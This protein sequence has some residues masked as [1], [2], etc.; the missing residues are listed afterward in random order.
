MKI[1][2]IGGTGVYG[3]DILENAKDIQVDTAFGAAKVRV[4]E[5]RGEEIAFLARHGYSHSVL[6]H[7]INYKANIA[8]LK[9]LGVTKVISTCAVGTLNADIHPGSFALLDQF[10]DFTKLRSYTYFHDTVAHVDFTNPYCKSLR[11]I[12]LK[13]A[14]E[15]NIVVSP[16]GCYGCTEGPRYETTAEISMM[17]KLGVDVVGMTNV[18]EVILAREAELCYSCIAIATNWAA[19]ITE[20]P[21]SHKD[22]DVLMKGSF[23]DLKKLFIRTL[24]MLISDFND[25]ECNSLLADMKLEKGELIKFEK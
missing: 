2:I 17:K 23:A 1:G 14:A 4:G 19:G 20:E 13:A 15:E 9:I 6:P 25:C 21:I 3:L 16:K 8:A 11:N 5:Y 24:D 12:I 18:P 22:V 10:I 7:L